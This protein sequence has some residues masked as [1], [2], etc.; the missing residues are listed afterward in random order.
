MLKD[1]NNA[2]ETGNEEIVEHL[3]NGLINLRNADNKREIPK[4]ENPDK[5]IDIVEEIHNFNKRQKGKGR[6]PDLATRLKILI[7]QHMFPK[8]TNSTCTDTSR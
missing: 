2:K 1:L 8:I 7:F 6:P 4:N 3:N 5:V